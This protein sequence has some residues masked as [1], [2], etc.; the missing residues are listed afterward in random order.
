LSL[1]FPDVG[2]TALSFPHCVAYARME[3]LADSLE[4]SQKPSGAVRM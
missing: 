4:T 2:G 3:N 1:L